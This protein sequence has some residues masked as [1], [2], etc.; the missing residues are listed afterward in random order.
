MKALIMLTLSLASACAFAKCGPS[1]SS[2]ELTKPAAIDVKA[3]RGDAPAFY[4][5][6]SGKHVTLWFSPQDLVTRLRADL[7][8]KPDSDAANPSATS[9][10]LQA[11]E[12]DLPLQA[13]MDAREFA[14]QGGGLY[15]RFEYLVADLMAEGKV[16][17]DEDPPG[18]AGNPANVV[19]VSESKGG[20]EQGRWFCSARGKELF[21][22]T[23]LDQ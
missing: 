11:I 23:Y 1:R 10:L 21:A 20:K 3:T 4:L 17:V 15:W 7:A 2:G 8:T 9:R 16:S 19:M 18:D 13:P 22:V 6:P 14:R 12:A 5:S